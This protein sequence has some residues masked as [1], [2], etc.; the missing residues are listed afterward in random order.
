MSDINILNNDV[1]PIENIDIQHIT[2]NPLDPTNIDERE[3]ELLMLNE[4]SPGTF[5]VIGGKNGLAIDATRDDYQNSMS[6]KGLLVKNNIVCTGT[7]F[8]SNLQIYGTPIT[9]DNTF[10]IIDLINNRDIPIFP[11]TDIPF[12]LNGKN[13]SFPHYLT[14]GP[15]G[16]SEYNTHSLSICRD[17]AG[18]KVERLQLSIQ[19]QQQ[20]SEM[21]MG[22]VGSSETSPAIIYTNKGKS[23]EFFVSKEKQSINLLYNNEIDY[24]SQYPKYA[25]DR[26]D[27]PSMSID[28]NDVVCIGLQNGDS[29]R[30]DDVEDLRLA[31]DATAYLKDLYIREKETCNIL[32]LDDVYIKKIGFTLEPTQI[33]PG[34]FAD[35]NFEFRSNVLIK[36]LNVSH[37]THFDGA[38]VIHSNLQV[39]DND[40][41]EDDIMEVFMDASFK[42]GMV[43]QNTLETGSMNVKG[44]LQKDGIN[45][46]VMDIDVYEVDTDPDRIYSNILKDIGNDLEVAEA[47]SEHLSNNGTNGIIDFLQD[48]AN[49]EASNIPYIALKILTE[50]D[51]TR[52][53]NI[54]KYATPNSINTDGSN[55]IVSGRVGVG[56]NND[57]IY[58][59]NYLTVDK[60][61]DTTPEIKLRSM[62]L[63]ALIGHTE[64]NLCFSTNNNNSIAFYPSREPT[65]F[66]GFRDVIP[67]L[68]MKRDLS[69]KRNL[70]GINKTL[71]E[72]TLDVNGDL[73]VSGDIFR[74]YSGGSRRVIDFVE[75]EIGG[76]ILTEQSKPIVFNNQRIDVRGSLKVLGGIYEGDERVIGF[77]TVDVLSGSRLYNKDGN[78]SL[79]YGADTLLQDTLDN[80]A[81]IVRNANGRSA[82][83]N[84]VIRIL[85]SPEYFENNSRYSG[86][87][88][89][90]NPR[91]P[92]DRWYMYNKHID[93]SFRIGNMDIS[94]NESEFI[95]AEK[96][97]SFGYNKFFINSETDDKTYVNGS[98]QIDGGDLTINGGDININGDG[99][100]IRINGIELTSNA[101]NISTL[102]SGGENTDNS[103]TVVDGVDTLAMRDNDIFLQGTKIVSLVDQQSS[104][105]FGYL[106]GDNKNRISGQILQHLNK[107]S[108][109]TTHTDG[110][111][112]IFNTG[113]N[114]PNLSL[115]SI[116]NSTGEAE[117]RLSLGIQYQ[118]GTVNYNDNK[119]WN[120]KY[121]FDI[122]LKEK[123]PSQSLEEV[124]FI[125]DN[126][127]IWRATKKSAQDL[128]YTIGYGVAPALNDLEDTLIH[129]FNNSS[130][131]NKTSLLLDNP[132]TDYVKF[133]MRDQDS[134]WTLRSSRNDFSIN[135]EDYTPIYSSSNTLRIHKRSSHTQNQYRDNY[136][137]EI[138]NEGGNSIQGCVLLRNYNNE[139]M[140]TFTTNTTE[141]IDL[142]NIS[143][144]PEQHISHDPKTNVVSI[145]Y[146]NYNY[147]QHHYTNLANKGNIY[148]KTSDEPIESSEEHIF[149]IDNNKGITFRR[150]KLSFEITGDAQ[151]S[152]VINIDIHDEYKKQNSH[153][154]NTA[155]YTIGYTLNTESVELTRFDTHLDGL[156]EPYSNIH[157]V[158][159]FPNLAEDSPE[160]K[161]NVSSNIVYYNDDTNTIKEYTV[162]YKLYTTQV[163]EEG[164]Y[165]LLEPLKHYLYKGELDQEYNVYDDQQNVRITTI[166][167]R[168]LIHESL[169]LKPIVNISGELTQ[170]IN[171]KLITIDGLT[172]NNALDTKDGS[173]T[174][175]N[176]TY[177]IPLKDQGYVIPMPELMIEFKLNNDEW[178]PHTPNINV[179]YQIY[180]NT[181]D[182]TMEVIAKY[183]DY[184]K[185]HIT[186]ET[187][188]EIT[189]DVFRHSF[190]SVEGTLSVYAEKEDIYYNNVLNLTGEGDLYIRGNLE[191]KDII[192]AGR[193]FTEYQDIID[194]INNTNFASEIREQNNMTSVLCDST[195]VSI[196]TSN[197]T[198]SFSN[199][200]INILK[201][202]SDNIGLSIK[203]VNGQ[204]TLSHDENNLFLQS[205]INIDDDT[206]VNKVTGETTF[207]NKIVANKDIDVFGGINQLSDRRV[208]TNI[209]PIKGALEK[210]EKLTGVYYHNIMTNREETGLIA[211]D[212]AMVLPEVV[213]DV[214]GG[215]ERYKT[216]NYGNMIGLLIEGIKE[217]KQHLNITN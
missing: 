176:R 50:T 8:T 124:S 217:I 101:I 215:M 133:C 191:A 34:S 203:Y 93:N 94:G 153:N 145:D 152:N 129:I 22:M 156:N 147:T 100:T 26:S 173:I 20:G 23:L 177:E 172:S 102:T 197:H 163:E 58:D 164:V 24:A 149:N 182:D 64:N 97:P 29:I 114:K 117:S 15:S 67:S 132:T 6:D 104:I 199:G 45:L 60:G 84:S 200:S 2:I 25:E 85:Q 179:S 187:I 165:Y 13:Y 75:N 82:T 76:L 87:D 71:P 40:T 59:G 37:S 142:S 192:V 21:L 79:G 17:S 78:I 33:Y 190:N 108:L 201:D 194:K 42:A 89:C 110:M 183:I 63:E 5:S 135:N 150:D 9:D 208:K 125:L 43:V 118:K 28:V 169:I 140:D 96:D 86:I 32:H 144:S 161:Y 83:N 158:I 4:Y 103:S 90:R 98:L 51:K 189:N 53:G 120:E 213:N 162:D 47:I 113:L 18:N 206:I 214:A 209:V 170:S 168:L 148:L 88:I 91:N 146:T 1:I 155:K 62:N 212:V 111:V 188:N 141:I 205:S 112:T 92:L 122:L 139:Q 137:M 74:Y 175:E 160:L 202:T 35:G 107:I 16:K 66:R 154:D 12:D 211:Q 73:S 31:V 127:D 159:N 99:K 54:L 36:D 216:I 171:T 207:K 81:L 210:I 151:V 123:V 109:D 38:V 52:S 10:K 65:P 30:D 70:V 7:I 126:N 80:T 57:N 138:N 121:K 48:N 119:P 14:I 49:I 27:L 131:S 181:I 198:Y 193:P 68:V 185:T 56:I 128:S 180:P 3:H 11:T 134:I 196:K 143:F 69:G 61:D 106:G 95:K 166:R 115:K 39:G 44:S 72:H 55:L 136:A 41:N 105:Y 130:S 174:L 167:R 46:N 204:I 157:T 178:F 77:K 116:P 19:S 195:N 186:M 184:T